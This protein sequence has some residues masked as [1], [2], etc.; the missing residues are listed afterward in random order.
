MGVRAQDRGDFCIAHGAQ[1]R[2]DMALAMNVCGITY[3]LSAPDGARVDNGNVFSITD[4]PRLRAG[5]GIGRS[6][7]RENAPHQRLM[8][9]YLACLDRVGPFHSRDMAHNGQKKKGRP[10]KTAPLK[11]TRSSQGSV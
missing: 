9:L 6:I 2:L 4:N 10:V 8:L 1:N 3:A 7:G 11:P 5:K